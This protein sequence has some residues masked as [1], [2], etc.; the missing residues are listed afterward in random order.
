MEGTPTGD[1]SLHL[2]RPVG[3]TLKNMGNNK[4]YNAELSEESLAMQ[5]VSPNF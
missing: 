2:Y 5:T 3:K 4:K 1:S